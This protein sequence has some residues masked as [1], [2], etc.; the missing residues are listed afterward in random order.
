[1]CSLIGIYSFNNRFKKNLVNIN[2]GLELLHTRGPDEK[3]VHRF[4]NGY[5]A[6]NRLIVRGEKGKGSMPF[7]KDNMVCFFNGEL[8]DYKDYVPDA[9]SDGEMILPLFSERGENSFSD[10]HGEFA[11]SLLDSE[12]L[13]L[14]RDQFGTKPLYFSFDREK[15]V[16]AS[17]AQAIRFF[18]EYPQIP[19]IRGYHRAVQEPY[20]SW[21]GIWQVPPGHYL[22][23]TSAGVQ[24]RCYNTWH[25]AEYDSDDSNRV[26]ARLK[27]T[28][29]QRLQYYETI[30]I[31]MSGGID[32]GIIAFMAQ[33][34]GVK[35]HIFTI[36]VMF[37]K[38]T[39]EA[40]TIFERL[41]RLK[42]ATDVTVIEFDKEHY[43]A[44]LDDIYSDNY[45]DN[46]VTD[47]ASLTT[48]AIYRAMNACKIRVATVGE[49][50]DEIF[51]GYP[52]R[53][54]FRCAD[55]W[56]RIWNRYPF[57]NSLY[58]TLPG[59]TAKNDRAGAYFSIESRYPYQD[60]ELFLEAQKLSI[61]EEL[62]WPLR[63]FL[64]KEVSYG[65]LTT[66]DRKGK[67][68]FSVKNYEYSHDELEN[69]LLKHWYSRRGLPTAKCIPFP[70]EIGVMHE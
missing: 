55:E 22:K 12:T 26:F 31:A 24:L 16:W 70:F 29:I 25:E 48:H 38:K 51:H 47:S 45:Y 30:G 50:G 44:A 49:G 58:S 10:L 11:I 52:Y 60:V 3:M 46:L 33:E 65:E 68:G 35:F 5:M 43:D 27:K 32:S 17:S 23:V 6:G 8:Y 66:F 56:L 21:C 67:I 4:D 57:Y 36:P 34:L 20:T 62:K 54:S 7:I 53:D 37:G 19:Y 63:L 59:F 1:M 15:V 40:D 61:R 64:E 14:V 9:I 28:L 18:G 2:R 42:K 13:Y 69:I 41:K 39:I